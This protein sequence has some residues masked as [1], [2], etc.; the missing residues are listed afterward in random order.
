[1]K[2]SGKPAIS[3]IGQEF[4]NAVDKFAV[5]VAKNNEAVGHLPCEHSEFCGILSHVAKKYVWK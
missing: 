3:E 5:K 4:D 1:M 2:M